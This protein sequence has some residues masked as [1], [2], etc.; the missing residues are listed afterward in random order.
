MKKGFHWE[1]QLVPQSHKLLSSYCST[2]LKYFR[3]SKFCIQCQCLLCVHK[4]GTLKHHNLIIYSTEFY[5]FFLL[6][7]HI[8]CINH[9]TLRAICIVIGF[10]CA[11]NNKKFVEL[12][13]SK[14]SRKTTSKIYHP[15]LYISLKQYWMQTLICS[16]MDIHKF[17]TPP[18]PYQWCCIK[19]VHRSHTSVSTT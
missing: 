19:I 11:D 16:K 6:V 14:L 3:C 18:P 7:K 1:T 9:K 4:N 8:K 17:I 10:R 2:K 13:V 5:C 15:P 12:K